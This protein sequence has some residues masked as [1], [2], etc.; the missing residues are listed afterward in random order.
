MTTDRIRW[1][2]QCN[3]I[4]TSRRCP[5]CGKDVLNLRIDNGSS[6]SPVFNQ[7]ANHIRN[8]LDTTYGEGCGKLLLP[9]ENTSL[10]AKMNGSRQMIV[11]GGIVGKVSDS[12]SITLNAS[13][14]GLISKGIRK[15]YVRCDHDSSYFVSKGRNMMVTG[16][17]ESS[18]GLSKGDTVAI[19]DEKGNPIAEGVMKLSSEELSSDR[20]VA[21]GVKDNKVTRVHTSGKKNE[22]KETIEINGP[23]LRPFVGESANKIGY[24]ASSYGYPFIVDLTPDIVS[25]ANLLLVLDAGYKPKIIVE[26][27]D[28]F[29]EFLIGKLG[30][31]TVTELPEKCILITEKDER[32]HADIISYSPTGGWDMTAIWMYVMMKAEPFDPSYMQRLG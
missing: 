5:R 26:K 24:L 29:T 10:F 7:Q 23:S 25:E 22:W 28:V 1:C 21:V 17:T 31:E 19:L 30:L 6:I 27:K 16:I 12:G 20:G 4:A 15:N 32:H 14:L 11:N 9:E 13:G 8:Y 3:L 18:E 2:M